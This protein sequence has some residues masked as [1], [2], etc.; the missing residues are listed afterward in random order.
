M[1]RK[2]AF[3]PLVIIIMLTMACTIGYEGVSIGSDPEIEKIEDMTAT[4][5]YAQPARPLEVVSTPVPTSQPVVSQDPVETT[6]KAA[7]KEYSV[8]AANYDCTCQVDGN[9]SVEFNFKGDQLEVLMNGGTPNV[10]DKIGENTYKRS[11]MGYYILLSGEGDS[12]V[13]TKVDE[14]RSAVII[15]NDNGY[16]MEHYQGSSS[17][18]CCFHTFT[19]TK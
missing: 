10:Y 1:K 2:N 4:A 13:E 6:E 18:P 8:T 16:V 19:D 12:A 14:E 5:Q 7:P 3:I 11:W 17:S 9:V 15:L